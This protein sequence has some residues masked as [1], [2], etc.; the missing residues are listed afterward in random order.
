VVGSPKARRL[1]AL[2][3]AR[4]GQVVSPEGLVDALWGARPPSAPSATSRRW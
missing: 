1:L 2:L 4:R 3:A